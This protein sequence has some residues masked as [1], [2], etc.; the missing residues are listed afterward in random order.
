MKSLSLGFG[1][2]QDLTGNAPNRPYR[3]WELGSWWRTWRIIKGDSILLGSGDVEEIGELDAKLSQLELG[4]FSALRQVSPT[5]L[6]VD[7]DNGIS[8]DFWT[9]FSDDDEV[10][11][12]ACPRQ[13]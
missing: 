9:T 5:D 2:E 1:D 12:I 10:F 8:I 3:T 6:C 11:H 4:S 7:L 13:S